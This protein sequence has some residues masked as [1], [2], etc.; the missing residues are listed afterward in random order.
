MLKIMKN[1]LKNILIQ[2]LLNNNPLLFLETKTKKT[3]LLKYFKE[4]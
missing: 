4:N 1:L 2:A 3:F